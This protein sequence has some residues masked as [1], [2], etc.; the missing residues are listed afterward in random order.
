MQLNDNRTKDTAIVAYGIGFSFCI[1]ISI[2][3]Q[4]R[5]VRRNNSTVFDNIE[6]FFRWNL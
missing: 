6:Y 5:N 2:I 1:L 3:Q 4:N